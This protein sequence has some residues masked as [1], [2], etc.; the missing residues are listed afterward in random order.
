M[1]PPVKRPLT[2]LA[3]VLA[4]AVLASGCGS[5]TGVA[6]ASDVDLANGQ[7]KFQVTCGGCHTLAA[8]GSK[9]TVGPNLDASYEQ[10]AMEGWE[11]SSFEATVRAQIESG[12]PDARPAMPAELLTG[13]DAQDVA[14]Y[15][16]AVAANPDAVPTSDGG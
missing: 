1:F 2:A 12:S 14:A 8:A 5:G 15:V 13:Q 7:K 6:P 3:A 9:G 16:A 4:T 11:R 10:P